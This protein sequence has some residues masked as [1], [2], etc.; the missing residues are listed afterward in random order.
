V[1]HLDADLYGSTLF[2]LVSV[3]PALRPGDILI[4]D[5]FA[6]PMNEFRAFL[7]SVAAVPIHLQLTHAVNWGNK[8]AFLVSDP[9]PP[10]SR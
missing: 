1:L 3:V 10:T 9:S 5:Q 8:V 7:D 4:F 2:V 6:D